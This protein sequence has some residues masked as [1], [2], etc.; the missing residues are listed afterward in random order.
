M[1]PSFYFILLICNRNNEIP[2]VPP[3]LDHFQRL[4]TTNAAVSMSSLLIPDRSHM[5]FTEQKQRQKQ[6]NNDGR[7]EAH[8]KD[9]AGEIE[10]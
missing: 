8:L 9:T 10:I 7:M 3:Q 1:L 5:V 2:P 4:P 6:N